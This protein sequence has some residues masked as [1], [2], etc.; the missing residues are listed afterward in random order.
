MKLGMETALIAIGRESEPASF[1]EN[2]FIEIWVRSGRGVF[3][4]NWL[5]APALQVP[6][7]THGYVF[8]WS[9]PIECLFFSSPLLFELNRRACRQLLYMGRE[10]EGSV[11]TNVR[12]AN[13][14]GFGCYINYEIALNLNGFRDR[15]LR[16]S[17]ILSGDDILRDI[18]RAWSGT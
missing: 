9:C 4:I 10:L 11:E 3:L 16:Y 8:E 6:I 18:Q 2:A 1:K 13:S 15:I 14:L 5:N 17:D 7:G 12:V